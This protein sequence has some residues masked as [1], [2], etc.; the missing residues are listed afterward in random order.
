MLLISRPGEHGLGLA[1]VADKTRVLFEKVL[2]RFPAAWLLPG[3]DGVAK[4]PRTI[5]TVLGSSVM[6]WS[7]YDSGSTRS[8]EGSW[9][10]VD[11]EA[12]VEDEAIDN[13]WG[14]LRLT[15]TPQLFGAG[16]PKVGMYSKRYERLV[17][18]RA[19]CAV[20]S[21]PSRDNPFI[22]SDFVE[23]AKTQM[24][25]KRFKQE[26]EA[27]FIDLGD[28]PRYVF[29]SFSRTKHNA[30]TQIGK[31]VTTERIRE[32]LNLPSASSYE[33]IAGIDANWS[34]A[35]FAVIYRIMEPTVPV[36]SI[37]PQYRGLP[38]PPP[39]PDRWIA[40]DIVQSE[41]GTHCGALA[42]SLI[43]AG[44]T[45]SNTVLIP[46]ASVKYDN[47]GTGGKRS[48]KDLLRGAGFELYHPKKNWSV[49]STIDSMLVKLAPVEGDPSLLLR[50]PQCNELAD[51][52][53]RV[54]WDKSGVKLDRDLGVQHVIDAARY[55]VR[56]FC[57]PRDAH[58]QHDVEAV[59]AWQGSTD[60]GRHWT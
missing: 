57:P 27:E 24:D 42:D 58:Y 39:G 17:A 35:N 45:R 12:D 30:A 4:K 25:E 50:F 38:P 14:C 15:S 10:V 55:P 54:V 2:K 43:D 33:F 8:M 29:R 44:Y 21:F 59:P 46:D 7:A 20:Y 3:K 19:N 13:L 6:F 48:S 22:S 53:E 5:R 49:T 37:A 51:A 52:M 28:G 1:P 31:W 26:M 60:G 40:W 16:T 11:E 32:R 23:I 18:D 9:G 41:A 34:A 36:V 47:H 56:F